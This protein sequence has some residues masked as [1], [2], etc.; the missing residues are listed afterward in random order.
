MKYH[1]HFTPTARKLFL[2]IADLRI[3]RRIAEA[4]ESLTLEPES[5]GKP[6]VG[7]L[8]GFRGLRVAGQRYRIIYRVKRKDA[9]VIA[10]AVGIRKQED[11]SDIYALARKLV[12]LFKL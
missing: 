6:L 9:L 4:V 3:Q 7:E 1:I 12:R 11:K 5:Q 8:T 10:L 2:G